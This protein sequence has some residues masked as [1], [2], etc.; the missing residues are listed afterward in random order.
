MPRNTQTLRQISTKNQFRIAFIPSHIGQYHN[1]ELAE[2]HRALRAEYGDLIKFPGLFGNKGVIFSYL[3]TDFEHMFRTEGI[4][5]LRRGMAT[6]DHYR[7]HIRPDLFAESG[8]LLN[9][10][11]EKWAQVRYCWSN[12]DETGQCQ[13]IHSI[14]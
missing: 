5:P 8:G 6:F 1:I 9:E 14:G 13:C 2:L 10:Q 11:G 7:K 4:W 12:Y 3:P